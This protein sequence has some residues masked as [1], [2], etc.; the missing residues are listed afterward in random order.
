MSVR[1][2]RVYGVTAGIIA[3]ANVRSNLFNVV[4]TNEDSLVLH[5]E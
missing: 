2:T 5:C 4:V 1:G 3:S